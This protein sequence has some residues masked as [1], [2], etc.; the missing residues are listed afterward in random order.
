MFAFDI[1]VTWLLYEQM[2]IPT[3]GYQIVALRITLEIQV[4]RQDI[5]I[6]CILRSRPAP[7]TI[8]RYFYMTVLWTVETYLKHCQWEACQKHFSVSSEWQLQ[9]DIWIFEQ[10]FETLWPIP[11]ER[12]HWT[13]IMFLYDI[14]SYGLKNWK[15]T[16]Q[17][18]SNTKIESST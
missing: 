16:K 11:C 6:L 2:C 9:I 1:C 10:L 7:R 8:L 5:L 3:A 14:K 15:L 18:R 17:S 12:T 4:Q 13:N